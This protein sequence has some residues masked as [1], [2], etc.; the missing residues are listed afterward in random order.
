MPWTPASE[1]INLLKKQLGLDEEFFIIEKVW[2][3]EVGI[4]DVKISGYK[5]GTI[6][7]CTQSSV[8]SDDL[9]LRKKK[10]IEKLNQY[11]SSPRIKNIKIKI[12]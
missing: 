4:S 6:F 3:K 9:G 8:A 10:I 5:N 7:A 2:E 11:L 1:I 12:E